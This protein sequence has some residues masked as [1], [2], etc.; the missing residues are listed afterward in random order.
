M[1]EPAVIPVFSATVASAEGVDP[2][3]D[4]LREVE[5]EGDTRFD[6]LHEEP[7][8]EE[9]ELEILDDAWSVEEC[10][11]FEPDFAA[12]ESFSA[13]SAQAATEPQDDSGSDDQHEVGAPSVGSEGE[14]VRPTHSSDHED[15]T[16]R[17]PLND[18]APRFRRLLLLRG[19]AACEPDGDR[20]SSLLERAH[21]E[22][23]R[24][25][26]LLHDD[27]AARS[28]EAE[29]EVEKAR[30]VE[31]PAHRDHGIQLA[32]RRF[33]AI[34]Q[35]HGGRSTALMAR[36]AAI[37]ERAAPDLVDPER[38]ADLF[39]WAGRRFAVAA[40]AGGHFEPERWLGEARCERAQALNGDSDQARDAWHRM[41]LALESAESRGAPEVLLSRMRAEARVAETLPVVP[42][43]AILR[44]PVSRGAV[45]RWAKRSG[46]EGLDR[47][48]LLC[49]RAR[50]RRE[51][52]STCWN[53][54][55]AQHLLDESILCANEACS[56]R[57]DDY[58][59]TWELGESLSSRAWFE[60]DVVT[61]T[62]TLRDADGWLGRSIH[63]APRDRAARSEIWYSLSTV[64]ARLGQPIESM[65]RLHRFDQTT[66]VKGR[67][68]MAIWDDASFDSIRRTPEFRRFMRRLRIDLDPVLRVRVAR[69][70]SQERAIRLLPG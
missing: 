61:S 7:L 62:A 25:R 31:D 13:Q 52:A 57:E 5:L 48:Q 59:A 33:E 46:I 44:R 50:V 32:L 36:H 28:V 10:D 35:E 49:A 58:L 66:W 45:R 69:R 55:T 54:E 24:Q 42:D 18:V 1:L 39:R 40:R 20:A 38:R 9:Y 51:Q 16:R 65:K 15:S 17:W 41:L 43:R 60:T 19:L 6:L 21:R 30:L 37:V 22:S 63:R 3:F 56:I 27:L 26:R 53:Q 29:I 47:Y 8:L 4:E 11:P 14:F 68:Q 12:A 70:S 23:R 2:V 64:A 67:T 34:E